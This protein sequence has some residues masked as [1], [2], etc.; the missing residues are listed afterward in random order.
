[1]LFLP[2]REG[3]WLDLWIV[4]REGLV[5]VVMVEVGNKYRIK[6]ILHSWRRKEGGQQNCYL[7]LPEGRLWSI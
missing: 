5:S 1:M 2:A 4:N 6:I 7:G 3:S